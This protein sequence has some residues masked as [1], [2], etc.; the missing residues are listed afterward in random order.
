[1]RVSFVQ[2]RRPEWCGLGLSLSIAN[3]DERACSTF[4]P[5][6]GVTYVDVLEGTVGRLER[7]SGVQGEEGCL[8]HSSSPDS[9]PISRISRHSVYPN[10]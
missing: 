9:L 1:M 8:A 4:G 7:G 6:R 3:L 2:L 5:I 10:Q